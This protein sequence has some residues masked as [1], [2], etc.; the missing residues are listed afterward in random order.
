MQNSSLKTEAHTIFFQTWIGTGNLIN[1][2]RTN[3]L[4]LAPLTDAQA[5]SM[6]EG[7]PHTY[8]WSPSLVARPDDWGTHI[9]VCGFF[10][11]RAINYK[12]PQD[13]LDFLA[14]GTRPLYIGLGSIVGHDQPRLFK[15]VRDALKATGRRAVVC[16]KLATVNDHL[17]DNMF[18]LGECPHEWLFQKGM[19]EFRSVKKPC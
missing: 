18:R 17:P 2:F 12:P 13:L 16:P 3:I 15:I 7:V 19:Y 6:M 4:K 1:H 8:C 11:S 5:R 14:N 10:F 9:D